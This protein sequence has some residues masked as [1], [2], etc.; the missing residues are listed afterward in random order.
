SLVRQTLAAPKPT[1]ATPRPSKDRQSPAVSP[2][3][4]VRPARAVEEFETQ[5]RLTP[6][7]R[8]AGA[9]ENDAVL[10]LFLEVM[11][12]QLTPQLQMGTI[13]AKPASLTVSL[14]LPWP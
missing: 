4:A 2:R 1:K 6:A 5:R 11:S 8:M 7:V 9:G 3:T 12:M 10:G 14:H 13:R